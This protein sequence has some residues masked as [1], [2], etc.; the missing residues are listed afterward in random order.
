ML[1]TSATKLVSVTLK[2]D[3][4]PTL[5][6]TTPSLAMTMIIVP[7]MITAAAVSAKELQLLA[8]LWI[9]ATKLVSVTLQL[10][11]ALTHFPT[12]ERLAM[13]TTFAP[14]PTLANLVFVLV[15]T[16]L[17]ALL[18]INATKLVFATLLLEL[19]R[20]QTSPMELFAM[21]T[22][23]ALELTLA[24]LVSV[25]EATMSP[26][27]LK[28]NATKLV[29]ATQ[30][31]DFAPTHSPTTPSLAMT[32]TSALRTTFAAKVFALVTTL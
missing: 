26:A 8:L 32:T 23:F 15:T 25:L 17:F 20:I 21:T 2:L 5:P 11:N 14:K 12:M 29:F 3:S 7:T 27:L 24:K 4:V 22:T 13:T 9:S 16:L 10:D 6:Q 31:L 1:Q 30:P 28:T 18:M 19:A